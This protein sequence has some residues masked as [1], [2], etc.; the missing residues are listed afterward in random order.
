M[1]RL[2]NFA[3]NLFLAVNLFVSVLVA[4]PVVATNNHDGLEASRHSY[5]LI[6]VSTTKAFSRQIRSAG[7]P[8]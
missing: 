8:L 5:E 3:L 2:S 6:C 4:G 1:A 7:F